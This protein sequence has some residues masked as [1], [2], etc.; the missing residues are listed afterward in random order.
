M[1]A[2]VWAVLFTGGHGEATGSPSEA[3]DPA[4]VARGDVTPG[5]VDRADDIGGLPRRTVLRHG[6]AGAEGVTGN[7]PEKQS[8]ETSMPQNAFPT[9]EESSFTER[10][11]ESR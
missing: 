1:A 2:L 5:Q 4:E 7:I 8:R 6:D 10:Q 11:G 9:E 3:I